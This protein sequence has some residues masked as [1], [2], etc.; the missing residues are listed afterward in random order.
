MS[1]RDLEHRLDGLVGRVVVVDL[2]APF[3]CLGTLTGIDDAHLALTDADFHDLRDSAATREVYV[4][5]SVRLGIRRNRAR[6]L[7]S[8]RDVVAI[9]LFDD[10]VES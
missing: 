2:A 1:D 9:A 7:V 6:V 3:V 10:V 4:Y 8:R 5:D